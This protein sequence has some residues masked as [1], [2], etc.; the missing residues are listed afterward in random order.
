VRSIVAGILAGGAANA[1]RIG[2]NGSLLTTLASKN[3]VDPT[4]AWERC[5][6][7]GTVAGCGAAELQQSG[8]AAWIVGSQQA[9]GAFWVWAAVMHGSTRIARVIESKAAI[10]RRIMNPV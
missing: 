1:A 2:R 9:C 8:L 6:C 7:T 3:E 10:V 5:P 4:A